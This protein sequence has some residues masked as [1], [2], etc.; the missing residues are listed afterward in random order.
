MANTAQMAGTS[1]AEYSIWR[2][3]GASS[4]GTMIEWYDFYIFGSL[5]AILAL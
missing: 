1:K 4:V 2:V 5:T 3:I